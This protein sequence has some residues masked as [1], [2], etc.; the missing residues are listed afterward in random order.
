MTRVACSAANRY[1]R[2]MGGIGVRYLEL[3]R[4]LVRA[5]FD[6][7]LVSPAAVSES[8][9]CGLPAEVVRS[10]QSR[11]APELLQDRDVVVAQGQLAN[12]LVA[13]ATAVPIVIDLY[14]P[15]LIENLHYSGP[16]G[17]D[18][19]RNDHASWVLQMAAGDLFLCSSAEQRLFYLGFLTALGR[20]HPRRI[21]SD[22]NLERLL[23]EVPF[24]ADLALTGGPALL[25]ERRPGAAPDSLRRRL[26]LVRRRHLRGRAR[27]AREP[28]LDGLGGAASTA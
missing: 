28:A 7:I 9:A 22:P 10:C 15:W 18:P 6:V 8:T 16:L 17:L 11:P 4:T 25:A 23:V 3:A 13:A 1:G 21:E 19:Y 27:P 2:P 14:D 26:R 12:D 24:G 5:G 20:V